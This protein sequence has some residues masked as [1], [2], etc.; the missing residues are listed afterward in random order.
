MFDNIC[1]TIQNNMITAEQ[2]KT[3]MAEKL[4]KAAAKL[5]NQQK[6]QVALN[7]KVSIKTIERYTSGETAEVRRLEFA[8][9]I[10]KEIK[11]FSAKVAA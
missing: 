10:L 7:L 11:T 4:Q 3:Q 1:K 6:M 5:D 9:E 2:L 8:E